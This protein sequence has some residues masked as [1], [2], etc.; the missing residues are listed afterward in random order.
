[1]PIKMFDC[2]WSFGRLLGF[3]QPDSIENRM[4]RSRD[5][6]SQWQWLTFV[7]SSA[8]ML[9]YSLCFDIDLRISFLTI[10]KN[11]DVAIAT[12]T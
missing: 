6:R 3:F 1:M 9:R 5:R 11:I 10:E 12:E 4:M 8:K 7:V 2:V